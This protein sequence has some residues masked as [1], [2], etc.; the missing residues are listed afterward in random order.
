MPGTSDERSFREI[1]DI[2]RRTARLEFKM[3]D[4]TGSDRAWV[5]ALQGED[6]PGGRYPPNTRRSPRTR[7]SMGWSQEVS[8]AFYARMSCQP[9]KYPTRR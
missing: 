2:I 8:K 5:P 1:K 7:V 6:V 3:V 4:D 9:P